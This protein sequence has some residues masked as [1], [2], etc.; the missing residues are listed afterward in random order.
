MMLSEI[1]ALSS[2]HAINLIMHPN[3][4][5]RAAGAPAITPSIQTR[6]GKSGDA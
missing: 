5:K 1:Q 4:L 3:A 6:E 2:W